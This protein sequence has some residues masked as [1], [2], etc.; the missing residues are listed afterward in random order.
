MALITAKLFMVVCANNS[1]FDAFLS[2]HKMQMWPRYLHTCFACIIPPVAWHFHS[3]TRPWL[4]IMTG[5]NK[6]QIFKLTCMHKFPPPSSRDRKLRQT[7][8]TRTLLC[9]RRHFEG[10]LRCLLLFLTQKTQ[11]TFKEALSYANKLIHFPSVSLASLNT[12]THS[13]TH[14]D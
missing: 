14:D 4:H 8:E 7:H 1:W 13:G 10:M 11:E 3:W 9:S 2:Y 6:T 5:L 12:H